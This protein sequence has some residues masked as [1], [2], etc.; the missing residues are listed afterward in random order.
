MYRVKS[1]IKNL[2]T[3]VS[4][5]MVPHDSKKTINIKVPSIGIGI[6]ILL[7]MVGSVY[8]A[9][10]AIDAFEYQRM[11]TSLNYYAAQFTEMRSTMDMLRQTEAQFKGLLSSGD[12]KEILE[13]INP[14]MV[15]ADT[16]SIDVE[17]LKAQLRKSAESVSSIKEY[18]REQRDLY[19]STPSGWPVTGAITSPFGER[20]APIGGGM[21]FHTGID[22]SVPTGTPVKSTAEGIV[23]FAGLSAG[24][25]NLVVIEHGLGYTTAYAHNSSITVKVGQR[26]KR[27]DIISYSGS[28]GNSTGPHL[29]YEVW[30]QGKA[31]NP[32]PYLEVA[33]NVSKK[34]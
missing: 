8:V 23:S 30:K 31:V 9:S 6:S 13:N 22:I 1:F 24:S 28:T 27:G 17:E 15:I 2:F 25:G 20:E 33:S 21:Q 26:V 18:L 16:G 5:M 32:Q 3:P 19:V 7:W 29:H 14:K 12:K 11:K 10:I 34:K 4:I